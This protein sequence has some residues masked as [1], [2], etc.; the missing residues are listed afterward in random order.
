MRL[1]DATCGFADPIPMSAPSDIVADGATG[2]FLHR[3]AFGCGELS[4]CVLL[5]VGEA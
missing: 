3:D 4:E 5:C 1:D 2:G